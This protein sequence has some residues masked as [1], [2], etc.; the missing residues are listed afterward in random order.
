MNKDLVENFKDSEF[1]SAK[2]KKLVLNDWDR[3]LQALVTDAE[4]VYVDK[5]GNELPKPFRKFTKRLYEHLHLHCSF[6]AHYDRLGFYNTY[7]IDFSDTVGFIRQFDIDFDCFSVEYG[8]NYWIRGD[9]ED[10]NTA[11][12]EAMNK[13]KTNIYLKIEKKEQQKDFEEIK[14]LSGKWQF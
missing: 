9:Y 11:M 13:Y 1:M 5:Y 4:K 10:L 7:F 8:K 2:D 6:I 3:F 14:R 12:I